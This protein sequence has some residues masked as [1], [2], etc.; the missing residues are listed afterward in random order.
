MGATGFSLTSTRRFRALGTLAFLLLLARPD[1]STSQC[2]KSGSE[3][4]IEA[5]VVACRPAN[6]DLRRAM[7]EFR[8][9]H[10]EWLK[11]TPAPHQHF[12]LPFDQL[13]EERV[14]ASH[15]VIV[16][17]ESLRRLELWRDRS[18]PTPGAVWQSYTSDASPGE[19]LLRVSPASCDQAPF[20]TAYFLNASDCCDTTLSS[21]DGCLL[22]LPAIKP[23]P[24][25]LLAAAGLARGSSRLPVPALS[26]P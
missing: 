14:K 5:K 24:A 9:W 4:L 23:A 20:G 2:L 17:L 15:G 16:R 3:W 7:E 1:A 13:I 6:D 8:A 11:T 25:D 26:P 18:R 19:V 22:H 10:D 21:D 12:A